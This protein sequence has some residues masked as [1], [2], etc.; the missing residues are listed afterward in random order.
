MDIQPY[1][2]FEGRCEEAIDFYKT[3]VGAKVEM[4]MRFKEAPADQQAMITPEARDK[5]MHAALRIGDSQ[6]LASDG[7]CTGKGS[8]SGITLT[9]N[10][11]SDAEAEKLFTAL[12]Q[13]G[14]VQMPM[15]E[16][17][18]ASRFGIV[19]DKFGVGWM[20]INARPMN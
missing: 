16:T 10:A 14:Q 17:F 12:G 15:A 2:S 9:L 18:F 11:G 7:Q 3:A 5:V 8:F 4:M 13:G 19:A 20:I 1:L 6:V